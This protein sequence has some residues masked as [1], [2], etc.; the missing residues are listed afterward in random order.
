MSTRG[1]SKVDIWDHGTTVTTAELN[2]Y[3]SRYIMVN[4][5]FLFY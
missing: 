3:G 5:L 1:I 4:G 2:D